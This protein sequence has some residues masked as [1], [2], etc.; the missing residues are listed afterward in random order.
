[1]PAGLQR[2]NPE[3]QSQ[4]LHHCENLKSQTDLMLD[5]QRRPTRKLPIK[6]GGKIESST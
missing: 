5:V 6:N 1:M 3:D 2:H 4:H